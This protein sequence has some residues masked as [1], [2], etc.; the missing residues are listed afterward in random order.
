MLYF[1]KHSLLTKPNV[2][3]SLHAVNFGAT[4]WNHNNTVLFQ[5]EAFENISHGEYEYYVS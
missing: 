2:C 3:R 4:G 1:V 5:K